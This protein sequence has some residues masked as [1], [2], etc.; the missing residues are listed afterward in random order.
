MS[1]GMVSS[2]K[3]EGNKLMS[4]NQYEIIVIYMANIEQLLETG[5]KAI[6]KR[7]VVHNDKITHKVNLA[8]LVLEGKMTLQISIT[9][10][11]GHIEEIH[12]FFSHE[13][14]ISEIDSTWLSRFIDEDLASHLQKLHDIVTGYAVAPHQI[15]NIRNRFKSII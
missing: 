12:P 9:I 13:Y 10:N 8:R 1:K 15:E 3:E 5:I 11:L 2:F 6:E 4:K 14:G 7:T